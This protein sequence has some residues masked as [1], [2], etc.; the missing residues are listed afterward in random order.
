MNRR[1]N[2]VN[3]CY[4]GNQTASFHIFKKTQKIR[5]FIIYYL[6]LTGWYV[7]DACLY[8]FNRHLPKT[9]KKIIVCSL[10]DFLEKSAFCPILLAFQQI[11][12]YTNTKVLFS[13]N[14]IGFCHAKYYFSVFPQG[15]S[16]DKIVSCCSSHFVFQ[17]TDIG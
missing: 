17:K 15:S 8:P 10:L 6:L 4:H 2:F 16:Y 11:V 9:Y 1:Y 5:I 12:Q 13:H 7:N 3:Y 14:S